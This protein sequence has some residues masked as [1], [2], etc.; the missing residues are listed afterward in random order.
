MKNIYLLLHIDTWTKNLAKLQGEGRMVRK[1][2]TPLSD[3]VTLYAFTR[4]LVSSKRGLEQFRQAN[5]SISER[6]PKTSTHDFDDV[7]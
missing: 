1:R 5:D 4:W 2:L 7:R 3:R 6:N